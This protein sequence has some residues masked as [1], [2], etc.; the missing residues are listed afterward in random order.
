MEESSYIMMALTAELI[1]FVISISHHLLDR[2]LAIML[3]FLVYK[4]INSRFS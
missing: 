3:T 1:K 2:H 4:L